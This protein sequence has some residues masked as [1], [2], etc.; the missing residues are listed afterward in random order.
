[1]QRLGFEEPECTWPVLNDEKL[2][3]LAVLRKAG[4]GGLQTQADE[5]RDGVIKGPSRWREVDV[6]RTCLI[7]TSPFFGRIRGSL[8]SLPSFFHGSTHRTWNIF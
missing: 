5:T 3:G 7:E 2:F 1:M 6:E 4:R 8:S